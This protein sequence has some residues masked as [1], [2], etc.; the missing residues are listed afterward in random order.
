MQG[1]RAPSPFD[2]RKVAYWLRYWERM[3]DGVIPPPVLVTID[4]I[5]T[6]NLQCEWCNA[7]AQMKRQQ[8]DREVVAQLPRFLRYWGVRAVC[9]AGG[10]EPTI[11]P[12]LSP[13]ING[14]NECGLEVGLVTNG[15]LIHR[16]IEALGKCKW[17]GVSVDAGRSET[18]QITKGGK[19]ETVIRNIQRLRAAHPSLEITYKYLITPNNI[20]EILHAAAIANNIGCNYFHTRPMGLAWFELQ[21]PQPFTLPD[22]TE[23]C[24]AIHTAKLLN[25]NPTF[26]VIGTVDK[27]SASWGIEHNFPKCMAVGMSMVISPDHTAGLCCDRR[28]DRR[29]QL[30]EW[31]NL[32]DIRRAWGSADHWD[33]I[34]AISLEQCPRCT[35][36]PH[37][38]L[39]H[40]FVK[41]DQTCKNFI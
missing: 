22:V 34:N 21:K 28:G 6:C 8:L 16:H 25:D 27:F 18:Y 20:N 1:D 23:A 13:L 38:E 26:K 2:G 7:K 12:D 5:N 15:T 39:Y 30:I 36:A 40:A 35:Y 4:P 14:L 32:D 33:M 29:T 9:I 41:S 24:K 11:H 10:G 17:V 3:E 31:G 19:F 37:N